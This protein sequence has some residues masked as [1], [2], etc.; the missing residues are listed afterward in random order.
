MLKSETARLIRA[1]H[2]V[3]TGGTFR[4]YEKYVGRN[5]ADAA[6]VDSGHPVGVYLDSQGF[7][8]TRLDGHYRP[9]RSDVTLVYTATP[10]G[11]DTE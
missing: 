8:T 9:T 5:V 3:A 2:H 7:F 4:S 1:S 10:E 6:A 11:G